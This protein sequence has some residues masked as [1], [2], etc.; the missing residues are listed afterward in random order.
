MLDLCKQFYGFF[1]LQLGLGLNDLHL[2]VNATVL[3]QEGQPGLLALL[4]LGLQLA[5]LCFGGL[6]DLDHFVPIATVFGSVV[7]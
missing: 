4:V 6:F 5:A 2:F 1:H 7:V 3:V